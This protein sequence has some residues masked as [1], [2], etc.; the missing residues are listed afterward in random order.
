MYLL[1]LET[2]YPMYYNFDV[3]KWVLQQLPPVL[4]QG[5]MAALMK[6]LS[7]PLKMIHEEF[8]RYATGTDQQLMH[9][10]QTLMLQKWLN[11]IF[12]LPSGTIYIANY[13]SD[14]VY[15][16]YAD[17][18][19]DDTYMCE[20]DEGDSIY[21]KSEITNEYGGFIVSVPKKFATEENLHTIRK[22]VDYYKVAGTIYKIET[23]E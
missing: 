20:K 19:P 21:L 23:D 9:N 17:E 22:W 13:L 2:R 15:L 12:N 7:Q 8:H 14:Q 11:D 16:H 10:S 18:L 6:C 1:T 4:C 3:R 5:V